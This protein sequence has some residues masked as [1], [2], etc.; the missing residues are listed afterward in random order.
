MSKIRTSYRLFV[1]FIIFFS[2]YNIFNK[3]LRHQNDFEK[4][5]ELNLY[6][7]NINDSNKLIDYFTVFKYNNKLQ[8]S[9]EKLSKSTFFKIIKID[10][11]QSCYSNIINNNNISE[12][13]MNK[14]LKL[15]KINNLLNENVNYSE[16]IWLNEEDINP[17]SLNYYNLVEDDYDFYFNESE[18]KTLIEEILKRKLK[19]ND[20]QVLNIENK[21]FYRLYSGIYFNYKFLKGLKIYNHKNRREQYINLTY[22][23]K[24]TE[25]KEEIENFFYLYSYLI[26]VLLKSEN[27]LTTF[28]VRTE[29]NYKKI[30]PIIS[31]IF[32][33]N[34]ENINNLINSFYKTKLDYLN[35]LQSKNIDIIK[36]ELKN[37][38]LNINCMSCQKNKGFIKFQLFG[39][40]T[41]MKILFS[42]DN[43]LLSSLTRNEL[44]SFINFLNMISKSMDKLFEI[45]D[46]IKQSH[47]QMKLKLIS[48]GFMMIILWYYINFHMIKSKNEYIDVN[49]LN[50]PK[51]KKYKI[52]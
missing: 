22:I 18:I 15:E 47:F 5:P 30:T 40:T 7:N 3:I 20:N 46:S 37:I 24:I 4:S 42:S 27:I 2:G 14:Y 16:N 13:E 8:K 1:N 12:C 39:I 35:F 44:A 52:N 29:K 38:S 51:N 23:R 25:N 21:I 11:N 9:I 50:K 6:S 48:V 31:D 34:K 41:M 43:N 19:T 26:R 32:N 49:P 28:N 45:D 17:D 33:Q 10:L 36:N